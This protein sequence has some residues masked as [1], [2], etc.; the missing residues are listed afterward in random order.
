MSASLAG[1]KDFHPVALGERAPRALLGANERL[2]E[3]GGDCGRI[4][5]AFDKQSG[6]IVCIALIWLSVNENLHL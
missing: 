6:E 2:V 4:T 3:R 1:R 5:F